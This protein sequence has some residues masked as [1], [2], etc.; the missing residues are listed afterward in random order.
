MCQDVHTPKK[1]QPK[2]ADFYLLNNRNELEIEIINQ[3]NVY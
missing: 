1:I 2:S 3:F